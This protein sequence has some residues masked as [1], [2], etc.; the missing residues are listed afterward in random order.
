MKVLHLFH[1][2]GPHLCSS[3]LTADQT[4]P[5]H[6]PPSNH[7]TSE[8]RAH[9]KFTGSSP[10]LASCRERHEPPVRGRARHGRGV[11]SGRGGRLQGGSMGRG[12]QLGQGGGGGGAGGRQPRG[13]K[14]GARGVRPACGAASKILKFFV[15][16]SSSSR[17]AATC[18]ARAQPCQGAQARAR[19]L[20]AGAAHRAPGVG[21]GGDYATVSGPR[22]LC[23]AVCTVAR[24]LGRGGLRASGRS[25]RAGGGFPHRRQ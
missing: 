24:P 25:R 7:P 3:S 6:R 1:F 9:R 10:G 14:G 16:C 22:P 8:A 18:T 4:R 19:G 17:I 23:H 2:L 20:A 11:P 5:F 21:G 13:V 12:G 15:Q